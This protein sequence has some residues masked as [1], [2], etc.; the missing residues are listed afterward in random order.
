MLVMFK[1]AQSGRS[2]GLNPL[3]RLLFGLNEGTRFAPGYSE[4]AF[5]S[6]KLGDDEA[7]Q[8]KNDCGHQNH[9]S[10]KTLSQNYMKRIILILFIAVA[11]GAQAADLYVAP[12]GDDS[13]VGTKE[14]PLATLAGARDAVR[15]LIVADGGTPK[16][17]VTVYFRGG[18]TGSRKRSCWVSRIQDPRMPP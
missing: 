13:A 15:K 3:A 11:L 12:N 16:K 14:M 8:L 6:I 9:H 18:F 5:C 7:N 17:P 1:S 10:D 2:K 4:N